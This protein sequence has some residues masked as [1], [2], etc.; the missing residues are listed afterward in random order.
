MPEI[1]NN[2]GIV[3]VNEELKNAFIKFN[4]SYL[5]RFS[6]IDKS[7]KS[8]NSSIDNISKGSDITNTD[9]N[10]PEISLDGFAYK[11]TLDSIQK[12]LFS[13]KEKMEE[14]NS[15]L[16]N[17]F[18][19]YLEST[20]K[21]NKSIEGKLL[22]IENGLGKINDDK[23]EENGLLDLILKGI[24]GALK[25]AFKPILDVF[26][27][28]TKNL[29]TRGILIRA[30][31]A[32]LLGVF[33]AEIA[34]KLGIPSYI[35][36]P[37]IGAVAGLYSTRTPL[38]GMGG[39][40]AGFAASVWKSQKEADQWSQDNPLQSFKNISIVQGESGGDYNRVVFDLRKNA[41]LTEMS[42]TDILSLQSDLIS[43]T[44]NNTEYSKKTNGR[45]TSA[46]GKYQITRTTLNSFMDWLSNTTEGKDF[47]RQ[48]NISR[49]TK[50]DEK[51]QELIAN[52]ILSQSGLSDYLKGKISKQDFIKRVKGRWPGAF[53]GPLSRNPLHPEIHTKQ[54][55]ENEVDLLKARWL[56]NRG[57]EVPK[58]INHEGSVLGDML[59]RLEE[60]KRNPNDDI[61]G[62]VSSTNQI[63]EGLMSIANNLGNSQNNLNRDITKTFNINPPPTPGCTDYSFHRTNYLFTG[64]S[65][66]KTV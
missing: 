26:G 38:G 3:S 66:S 12:K 51:T 1:E 39:A 58:D 25:K 37:V 31:G 9:I 62:W 15:H 32:A 19:K 44:K 33:G 4:N 27:V 18:L 53:T 52:W 60:I 36:Y 21:L 29:F 55:Q 48:F 63:T 16:F 24:G 10:S 28:L 65:Y 5:E 46:V 43:E 64:S 2:T 20:E 23:K 13:F 41:N 11:S 50:F 59:K 7:I 30:F 8:L 17:S 35:S 47:N 34:D 40:A 56:Q 45:G 42:I 14:I 61:S 6:N 49:D 54:E 57:K 22:D